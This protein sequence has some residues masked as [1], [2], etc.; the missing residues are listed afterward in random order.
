MEDV[1][2]FVTADDG[3]RLHV[4]P[5]TSGKPPLV[6]SNSLGTNVHLFDGQAA[7][8][9]A[10]HSV[11][12]YDTRGH[13]QSDAPPG[14]YSIDRLGRDLLAIIDATGSVPVDV[15]GVSIGGMTALWAAIHAP[16]K[17]RRVILA[18]T[19]AQIGDLNTWSSRID[20]A[21]TQGMSGIADATMLRWFTPAFRAARPDLVAQFHS[22]ITRTNPDGYAGCC[23]A[24]RDADLRALAPQV[25]CPALVVTGRHDPATPPEL[26]QWLT[27]QIPGAQLVE[28]DAAHLSNVERP[29]EFNA[30]VSRFM[31]SEGR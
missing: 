6:F 23:A 20:T 11:W 30:A 17:V 16:K 19:A 1:M 31:V 14:E 18:N 7:A 4:M 26:G 3:T 8:F 25:A 5:G 28:F 15:C 2:T 10:T 22:T 29:D 9:D 12:R 27:E 21:R 13:G 24:L